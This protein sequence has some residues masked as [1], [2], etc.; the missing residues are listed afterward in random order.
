MLNA[1][2]LH[3]FMLNVEFCVIMT[4]VVLLRVVAHSTFSYDPK[5]GMKERKKLREATRY[6]S[7]AM[8]FSTSTFGITPFSTVTLGTTR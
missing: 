8:E 2:F 7:G 5:K 3:V 6:L 4:C 1:T